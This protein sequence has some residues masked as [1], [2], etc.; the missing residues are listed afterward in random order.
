MHSTIEALESRIA[1]ASI[2]LGTGTTNSGDVTLGAAD[3]LSA[4]LNDVAG[5]G[6]LV[7]TGTVAIN[8][9]ALDL[10]VAQ[11]PGDLDGFTL[12]DN[13]DTDAIT[14]TFSGLPEGRVF[15]AD[16]TY[17]KISYQGGDG[18]DVTLKAFVPEVKIT[19]DGKIATFNDVDGDLVTVK[20]TRG[21]F[22]AADF[23]L[24][25]RGDFIGGAQLA[26]L[27]LD[28][29]FAGANVTFTAKRDL[30]GGNGFVNVGLIDAAG[31][32]LGTVSVK[33]DLGALDAS[34]LK[35]LTAQSI[36]RLGTSTQEAG[37]SVA[38]TIA[39]RIGTLTVK[40][41]AVGAALTA[42]GFGTIKIGGSFIGGS[43]TS[44]TD[45]GTLSVT[46]DLVGTAGA[47]VEIAAFGKEI[48]PTKGVD[49]AL[50]TLSVGGRVEWTNV[51]LGVSA[52]GD[53]ADASIGTVKVG[54]DWIASSLRAA[55][56]PGT[57]TFTGTGD[58]VSAARP[59]LTGRDNAALFSQI[60][61]LT[62]KGQ[63]F[64]TAGASTDQFGIS[65]EQ[66]KKASIGGER[67][68]LTIGAR[69]SDDF[70]RLAPTGPG[71]TGLNSDVTLL[72][73]LA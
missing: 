72:E 56:L 53:N 63:V 49:L 4:T 62:I 19:G 58:D 16:G 9:A 54:G 21:T 6:K 5:S 28:S 39:A 34:S 48:A 29:D 44:G 13:D 1:P 70:F 46:H 67:L 15:S 10:S 55:T 33:G 45:I 37:G 52:A 22:S 30:F 23:V 14:G 50:K 69:S 24:V 31:V 32:S 42:S 8:G 73:V 27:S 12:I 60:A 26:K 17:F 38:V 18:N 2:A 40:S 41:D 68:A 59:G 51:V 57:D 71:A 11:K 20:T 47:P 43:I 7:V 3:T 35:S 65:A 25:P 36:G 61:S 66:I 64:G